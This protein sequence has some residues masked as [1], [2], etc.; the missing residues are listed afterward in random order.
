MLLDI[1]DWKRYGL[2]PV[3]CSP[4][5]RSEQLWSW[6]LNPYLAKKF[7]QA[8]SSLQDWYDFIGSNYGHIP[9]CFIITRI[10][11]LINPYRGFNWYTYKTCCYQN[12][13]CFPTLAF[14]IWKSDKYCVLKVI[15]H[16]S[17]LLKF[18]KNNFLIPLTTFKLL[19]V[20]YKKSTKK[21]SK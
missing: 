14:S 5:D 9:N 7:D 20:G 10:A 11:C 3:H 8:I 1:G 18:Y 13:R 17:K 6:L 12:T 21:N 19:Y 2:I 15:T 4:Q 16:V